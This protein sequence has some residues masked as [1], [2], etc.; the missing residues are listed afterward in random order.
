M[1]TTTEK[2]AKMVGKTTYKD[3]REGFGGT[4]FLGDSDADIKGA[5]GIAQQAVG[6]LAVQVL[7]TRY[8]GTLQHERG[9]R[10]AWDRHLAETAKRLG[11]KRDAHL[12]AKQRM[13]AA[14]AIRQL[15]GAKMI[16][17]EIA[18]YAW[19]TCSRRVDL[20]DCVNTCATWLDGMRSEAQ[21]AFLAAMDV[22]KP[23]KGKK[24]AA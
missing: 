11:L 22:I 17:F 20:E 2:I 3:F 1:T 9:I 6:P 14:L 13:A 23:K 10:R 18:E 4:T 15:A 21:E 12:V 7:E 24:R 8:A 19:M 16:Q 5:L